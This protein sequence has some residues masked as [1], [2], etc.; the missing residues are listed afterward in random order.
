MFAGRPA[1]GPA[2]ELPEQLIAD[3]EACHRAGADV[4]GCTGGVGPMT[5]MTVAGTPV[6]Q[7]ALAFVAGRPRQAA[8]DGYLPA[9]VMRE[10]TNEYDKNAIRVLVDGVMVGYLFKDKAR[11]WNPVL[12]EVEKRGQVLTGAVRLHGGGTEPLGAAVR[13]RDSLPN[14]AGPITKAKKDRAAVVKA[15][16]AAPRLLAGDEWLEVGREL[17]RLSKQESVRS[18]QAAGLAVKQFRTLLPQLWG[19]ANALQAASTDDVVE[20]LELLTAA[21]D[22]AEELL[23]EPEDADE[24]ED[25]HDAFT[26]ALDDLMEELRRHGGT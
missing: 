20:F 6:R 17:L 13:L 7:E 3:A 12:R 14:Y 9:V 5:E 1:P 21:E 18:K 22:A 2:I 11:A 19:H 8:P 25:F 4:G 10:P 23:D 15:A 24:R 26:G 16:D